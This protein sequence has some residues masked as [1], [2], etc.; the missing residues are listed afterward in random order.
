[1]E[2]KHTCVI[3]DDESQAHDVVKAYLL[4]FPKLKF[5]KSIF[6]HE[7]AIQDINSNQYDI[8]FL[9]VKL[10]NNEARHII[11]KLNKKPTIIITSD[12]TSFAF[13]AF[14]NDAVDYLKKPITKSRFGRAVKKAIVYSRERRKES[15]KYMTLK[16]DGIPTKVNQDE[17]IY[18]RSMGNYSKYYIVNRTN[19]IVIN[20]SFS[21]QLPK[22]NPELFIQSHRTCLVNTTFMVGRRENELI[23]KSDIILPIGRKFIPGL[24]SFLK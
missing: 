16:I 6:A 7:E 4:C 14:E 22:L 18:V 2:P 3:V 13:D 9:N 10:H 19:P 1:M 5:V 21:K 15:N 24:Q 23:L 11:D 17:I 8:V 20:E 12:H